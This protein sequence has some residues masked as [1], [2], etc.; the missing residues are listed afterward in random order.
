[1]DTLR[2]AAPLLDRGARPQVAVRPLIIEFHL[3]NPFIFGMLEACKP[4]F[5]TQSVDDKKR[6]YASPDFRAAFRTQF[7]RGGERRRFWEGLQIKEATD[8]HLQAMQWSSVAQ[9]A[10]ARGQ[11][12]VEVFFDLA[13]QDDLKL[14]YMVP[15]LDI[16]PERVGRKLSD[17]RTMIGLSDGGAH[18]DML[19]NAGYPTYLLGTF[20]RERQALTL[21][22]AIKRITSEPADFFGLRGR[23]RLAPGMAADIAIFDR[24][25]VGC[26]ERPEIRYDLPRQGRRLV[27][28]AAGIKCVIV[29]GEVLLDDGRHT[30]ALPGQALRSA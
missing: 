6:I 17:P 9:I 22:Y 29:N 12:P 5:A 30:G 14:I 19:C 13:L 4:L 24:D 21:E 18:V 28:P 23:G 27:S 20:V 16:D 10:Q 1:M 26:S 25:T 7:Q 2:T 3:R 11:D 15:L 8:P